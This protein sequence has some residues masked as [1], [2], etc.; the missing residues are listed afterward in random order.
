MYKLKMYEKLIQLTKKSLAKNSNFLVASI[1]IDKNGIEYNGVNVE[2]EIPTISLCAE[3]NALTNSFTSGVRMGDIK[4]IHIISSNRNNLDKNYFVTPCGSCRQAIYEAS[5]GTAKVF[6]Y[7]L[8]GESKEI[9][10]K[11]L[12]PLAFSGVKK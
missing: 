2:Y 11:E 7:N 9:S 10:I 12:L 4:E 3:R 6:M 8:K 5:N 1:V